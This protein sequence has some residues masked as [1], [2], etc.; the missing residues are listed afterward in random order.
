MMENREYSYSLESMMTIA[1][2][3]Q[4]A[5][6]EPGTHLHLSWESQSQLLAVAS[7]FLRDGLARGKRALWL[8]GGLKPPA[9]AT[10]LRVVGVDV[11]AESAKATLVLRPGPTPGLRPGEFAPA[12]LVDCLRDSLARARA[13]GHTGLR[14]CIDLTGAPATRASEL[15]ILLGPLLAE[16]TLTVL[17]HFDARAKKSEPVLVM[18]ELAAPPVKRALPAEIAPVA[19]AAVEPGALEEAILAALVKE[20]RPLKGCTIAR[21]LQRLCNS[22]FRGKLTEMRRAG[23]LVRHDRGGYW[24]ADRSAT[25]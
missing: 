12:E 25:A 4:L 21:R 11:E 20:G 13:A 7:I 14:A 1:L 3:T 24:L 18:K 15:D 10:A 17:T 6:L 8:G 9:L 2:V 23:W 22:Y 5:L 16:R 19:L